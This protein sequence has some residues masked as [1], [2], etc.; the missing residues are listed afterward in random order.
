[1]KVEVAWNGSMKQSRIIKTIEYIFQK[2]AI[3]KVA[4]DTKYNRILYNFLAYVL[5]FD[6][7]LINGL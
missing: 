6:E 3:L 1:M 5:I 7:P 2:H 4:G